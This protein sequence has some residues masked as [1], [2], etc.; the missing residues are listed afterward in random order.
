MHLSQFAHGNV[1]SSGRGNPSKVASWS[2]FRE[3]TMG[4]R[5]AW[6]HDGLA[7]DV[8]RPP[9]SWLLL[10]AWLKIVWHPWSWI[11]ERSYFEP[12]QLERHLSLAGAFSVIG[13]FVCKP[14]QYCPLHLPEHRPSNYWHRIW[15][16]FIACRPF[17]NHPLSVCPY[18]FSKQFLPSLQLYFK[19]KMK[20]LQAFDLAS[21]ASTLPCSHY[22]YAF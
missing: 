19:R 7:G 10:V 9:S 8:L 13:R 14:L 12:S 2:W 5:L 3:G 6:H 17:Q 15:G 1:V 21:Q 4:C 22:L 16:I 20:I 11:L 18:E